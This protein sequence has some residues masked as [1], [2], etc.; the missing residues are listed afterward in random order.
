MQRTESCPCIVRPGGTGPS[1]ANV[2]LPYVRAGGPHGLGH[3]P[4]LAGAVRLVW[5]SR[6]TTVVDHDGCYTLALTP[7]RGCPTPCLWGGGSGW[8]RLLRFGS[9]ACCA[10]VYRRAT[11]ECCAGVYRRAAAPLDPKRGG[12]ACPGPSLPSAL[13]LPFPSRAHGGLRRREAKTKKMYEC[14]YVYVCMFVC[15]YVCNVM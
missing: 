12:C 7:G 2:R 1:S 6:I 10:G 4:L 11:A 15:M 8:V 13:G 3:R 5:V 14:M 9:F